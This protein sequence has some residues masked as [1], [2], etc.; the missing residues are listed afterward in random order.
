MSLGLASSDLKGHR[1]HDRYLLP[2]QGSPI[3]AFLKLNH[4]EYCE[5]SKGQVWDLSASG[6]R[7]VLFGASALKAPC[8]GVLRVIQPISLAQTEL[9]VELRWSNQQ[10]EAVY[11]GLSLLDGTLPADSF[12]Q[13]FMPRSWT[14]MLP[15]GTLHP[16]FPADLERTA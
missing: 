2:V 10:G 3:D 12:L 15:T 1:Q 16:L 6:I 4:A 9:N 8:H 7:V 14:D 11:A 13:D 5:F